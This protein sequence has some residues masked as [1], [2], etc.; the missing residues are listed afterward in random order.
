MEP[1]E[2]LVQNLYLKD[3]KAAYHALKQLIEESEKTDAIY[4]YFDQFAAMINDSNSYIRTR[5]LSLIAAN[6][7]WDA[8]NKIDAVLDSYLSH[9][10]DEKPITARQCIKLLPTIAAYKPHLKDAII[11]GLETAD[12][13]RYVY[14]DS[15]L[16]L[17]IKDISYSLTAIHALNEKKK[18]N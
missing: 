3:T 17:I 8:E 6:A 18:H 12:L 15:M 14:S 1:I 4:S 13:S 7:K 9:I 5:G 10:T 16:P 11:L 2:C